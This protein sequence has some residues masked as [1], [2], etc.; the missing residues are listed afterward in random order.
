MVLTKYPVGLHAKTNFFRCYSTTW[1]QETRDWILLRMNH[2]EGNIKPVFVVEADESVTMYQP[3]V[4]L[5]TLTQSTP[6]GEQ[7]VLAAK[8]KQTAHW[9]KERTRTQESSLTSDEKSRICDLLFLKDYQKQKL[10]SQEE[11]E[12]TTELAKI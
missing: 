11:S 3:D 2:S 9:M 7:I 4:D 1:N 10:T 12:L 6:V 5:T 8:V